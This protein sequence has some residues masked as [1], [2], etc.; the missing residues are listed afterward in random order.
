MRC[1]SNKR[2]FTLIEVLIAL[3]ILGLV[4]VVL[5]QTTQ[6]ATDQSRYLSNKV[7]ATWIAKD[8]VTSMR[9]ALR[10]GAKV[11]FDRE[12]TQQARQEW[13]SVARIAKR[14][15]FLNRIEVDVFLKREPDTPIYTLSAYIPNLEVR[16]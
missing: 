12:E 6:N 3:V 14:T 2:G 1:H 15:Q 16:P 10:I 13:F 9:L 8:R 7:I 5:V 11:A 4:G